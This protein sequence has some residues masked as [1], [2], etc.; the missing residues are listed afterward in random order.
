MPHVAA[1]LE[2]IR[3]KD[4]P[5]EQKAEAWAQHQKNLAFWE[6]V[7]GWLTPPGK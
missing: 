2:I 4:M 6:R 5:A 3:L 7:G 1:V